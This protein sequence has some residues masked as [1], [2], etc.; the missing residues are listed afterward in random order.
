VRF[1]ND[2]EFNAPDACADASR[3]CAVDLV[4]DGESIYDL[5]NVSIYVQDTYTRGRFTGQFGV[6]YDRN[7]DQA[8]AASIEANPLAGPWLPAIN[9]PGAD[10]GVIFNN[11][12]PRLGLTYDLQGTGKTVAK[13]NYARYYGQIGTGGVAGTIN[14][15]AQTTLRYPWVDLDHDKV[16]DAGEISLSANPQSTTGNWSA[17]NPANTVSANSIDPNLKN[18]STDEIIV[19]LDR[20]IG[21][22]FAVGANYIW[23]RYGDFQFDRR[24]GLETSDYLPVS[25]TPPASTCPDGCPTVTYFEPTFQTPTVLQTTNAGNFNRTYNGFEVTGRKRLAN[26]WLMN[27]SFAYNS[28]VVNFNDF[29]GSITSTTA[30]TLVTDPTN[31]DKRDGAQYDYPT[32][33]SGIGNVYINSK[34]LFKLSGMYQLPGSVNVSAFYNARQGYPFERFVQSPARARGAGVVSVLVDP[35]G[36]SRLPNFQNLDFHVERPVRVGHARFVPSMDIFN[37]TNN[38][39]IQAIRG[40]LNASNANNIQATVAPRVIRVGVRFNW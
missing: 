12:S 18:D 40:T 6:R 3:N 7:H 22:G 23:R 2:T 27:T 26:R 5:T 14:P 8:L 20:E 37:A 4:R 29:T 9:F 39:T 30:S 24:I 11:F 15:V 17:A 33:G 31:R 21:A 36:E 35:V 13:A 10:P 1:P 28:T 38:N 16:A 32:S 25:F 19:G 34:W